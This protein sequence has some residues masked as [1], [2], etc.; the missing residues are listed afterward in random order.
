[1]NKLV[2]KYLKLVKK[3]PERH[4]WPLFIFLSLYFV[5]PYSEFVVTILALGYFKFEQ[6]YRRLFDKIVSPLPDIIK[7]G[8]SVIFFL[9]MLDDTLFYAAIILGALWTNR[10]VKKLKDDANNN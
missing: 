2:R 6:Q 3:I 9:V 10:E 8:A 5:V 7:Y 1:M 4:Y